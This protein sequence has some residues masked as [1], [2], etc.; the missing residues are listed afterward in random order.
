M[1]NRF[2]LAPPANLF[3]AGVQYRSNVVLE[4]SPHTSYTLASY[5]LAK[6]GYSSNSLAVGRFS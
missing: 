4:R 3:P 1:M 5:T 2:H 6:N